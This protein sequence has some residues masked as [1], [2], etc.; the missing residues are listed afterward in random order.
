MKR[1]VGLLLSL[2][3]SAAL[4]GVG[5]AQELTL[6]AAAQPETL[7]PQVTAA[8]SSFQSTK[9]LYDTLVEVAPDGEIVA[10]LAESWEVAEDGSTVTFHLT[11][12]TFH[13]GT[14]FD[15]A[16]VK[17]SIERIAD[18][19]TGSPK[20]SEFA[21]ISEI[22]TPDENTVVLHLS[23][24]T[25]ALLATLASGWGAMLPSEKVASG[26]DFGN[27]PVGTGP[28]VLDEW[29]RDSFL[30]LDRFEDYYKGPVGLE[31]VTIRFVPDSAV[32]LQGLI[33]GEF[34]VIDTV[35]SADYGTVESNPDLELV[36]EPSGLVLVGTINNRREYLDD[37]QV[38]QALNYAVDKQV[39][40]DVAYGGGEPVGTFMEVGSPWLPDSIGHFA[41]DPERAEEMLAEAGVPEEFTL[42]IVLPQ[43]YPTHITA[44]Q[45]VQ[46]MLGDVG[47]ESEIR[48]VE[49]GVW[50]AEVY[51]GQHDFD[52]TVIGHTGKLDPT[53]RLDGYGDP[54]NNY[55]GYDNEEVVELLDRAA[56]T[57]DVEE[58]R[59]LYAQV[60]TLMHEEAPFIYF[61]TP[62]RTYAARANV[63]GFWIT[64]LL[65]TFDFRDVRID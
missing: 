64:P 33:T 22:E 41:Y 44:G 13:D 51:G 18:P 2:L 7:D 45:I 12:A 4:C 8:T 1:P 31:T 35:A 56:S 39:V 24:P 65:D 59:E 30:R 37:P 42:D 49:W 14:S 17:A 11:D 19:A 52:I 15:S 36:R 3:V 60:L 57:S 61:G 25:P 63:S 40:L 21:T 50:L 55:A 16:D 46:D 58:R 9:S 20:A 23:E 26:H 54:D 5:L 62:F 43:P 48:I 27:M 6:A 32:Q 47:I 28:F 29:V 38:R 34:D 10:A 53:G